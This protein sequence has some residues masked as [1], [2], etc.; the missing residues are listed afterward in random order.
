MLYY[1]KLLAIIILVITLVGLTD[2]S[3][4]TKEI[5]QTQQNENTATL[6]ELSIAYPHNWTMRGTEYDIFFED[7]NKQSVGGIS[8]VGYYGSPSNGLPNHSETLSS[9]DITT[10]IGKGKLFTL[11]RSYPAASNNN[12]TWIEIH[13]IIPTENNL[14]YDFWVKDNKDILLD[15]LKSINDK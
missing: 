5:S 1:R 2:C 14:A 11:R 9:E 13:A 10:N 3:P 7:E 6:G 12:Q 15:I 8:R 4:E